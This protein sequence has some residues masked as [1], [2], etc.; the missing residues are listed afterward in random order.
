[1]RVKDGYCLHTVCTVYMKHDL[2]RGSGDMLP[3]EIL[4]KIAVEINLVIILTG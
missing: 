1:M 3:Q 4:K 2:F